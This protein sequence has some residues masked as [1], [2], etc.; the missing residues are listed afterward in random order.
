MSER[1]LEMF[2]R[3]LARTSTRRPLLGRNVSPKRMK[4]T[5]RE[6]GA[7]LHYLHA[8]GL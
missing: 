1:S 3:R 6:S 2:E 5:A 4:T 8:L 7:S